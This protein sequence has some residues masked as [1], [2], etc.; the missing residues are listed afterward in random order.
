MVGAR[1]EG[2]EVWVDECR[3]MAVATQGELGELGVL[4]LFYT[5][6]T[7]LWHISICAGSSGGDKA[8]AELYEGCRGATSG[9][10]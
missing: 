7:C 3:G 6:F 2:Q 8:W 10:G 4:D 5:L 9:V 1:G